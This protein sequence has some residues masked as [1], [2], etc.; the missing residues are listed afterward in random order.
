[1]FEHLTL[2]EGALALLISVQYIRPSGP[3]R[4][5]VPDG[6]SPDPLYID[7]VHPGGI[8]P[9]SEDYKVLQTVV[10]LSQ[11]FEDAGFDP[12]PLEYF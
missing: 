2:A 7:H 12:V 9:G 10:V 1:M 8:R 5:A 4:I 11:L 3:L 6:N